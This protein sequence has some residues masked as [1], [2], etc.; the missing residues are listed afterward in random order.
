MSVVYAEIYALACVLLTRWFRMSSVG[1]RVDSDTI[2]I[3]YR[4]D[5]DMIP[6]CYRHSTVL[7]PIALRLATGL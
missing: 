4:Y 1:V 2:P 7:L 5:S 3:G 6:S